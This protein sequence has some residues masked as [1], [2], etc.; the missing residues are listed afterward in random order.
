MTLLVGPVIAAPIKLD[1]PRPRGP[2]GAR[3]EFLPAAAAQPD[4]DQ[5]L[6]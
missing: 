3:D 1:R 2:T 4:N 6:S 5:Q